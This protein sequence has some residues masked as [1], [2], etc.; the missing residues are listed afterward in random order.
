MQ[1]GQKREV[2]R[3]KTP[4]STAPQGQDSPHRPAEMRLN[5]GNLTNPEWQDE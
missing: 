1:F 4:Q 5:H 2:S 3:E